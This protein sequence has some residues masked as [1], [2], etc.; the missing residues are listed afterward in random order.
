MKIYIAQWNQCYHESDYSVLIGH[1]YMAE[2]GKEFME[3][4]KAMDEAVFWLSLKE[5]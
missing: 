2:F 1:S 4:S 5:D 3:M